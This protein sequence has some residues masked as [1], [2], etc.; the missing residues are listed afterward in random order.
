MRLKTI[1]TML[2]FPAF[3]LGQSQREPLTAYWL[4]DLDLKTA[5]MYDPLLVITCVPLE[6]LEATANLPDFRKHVGESQAAFSYILDQPAIFLETNER[7][8]IWNQDRRPVKPFTGKLVKE[9]NSVTMIAYGRRY[10]ITSAS[11]ADVIRLLRRPEGTK[12]LHRLHS[13]IGGAERTVHAIAL[14]LEDQAEPSLKG[15]SP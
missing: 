12:P 2:M 14:I 15:G 10:K 8:S 9:E 1:L 7:D 3:A 4:N 13:P 6:Q 5:T 11:T